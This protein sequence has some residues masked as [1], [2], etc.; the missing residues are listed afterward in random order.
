MYAVVAA[1]L[2]L[3]P[4]VAAA[5]IAALVIAAMLAA[6]LAAGIFELRLLILLAI[7]G[8]AMA[9]RLLAI[10]VQQLREARGELA[11]RAADAE[12]IRIARDLHDVLGHSL[13]VIVLKSQLARRLS[14]GSRRRRRPRR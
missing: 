10:V 7:G 12:R 4:L 5:V 9:V 2:A 11:R 1:G 8:A 6:W 3:A 14:E 13:S